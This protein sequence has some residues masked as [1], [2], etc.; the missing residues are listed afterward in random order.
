MNAC[1]ALSRLTGILYHSISP[2]K[3]TLDFFKNENC[4]LAKKLFR[5]K[6]FPRTIEIL[7]VSDYRTARKNQ[8]SRQRKFKNL[9]THKAFCDKIK[10]T[11]VF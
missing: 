1:L 9:L 4:K 10:L 3:R 7:F 2:I 6:S 5:Q 11:K 8:K